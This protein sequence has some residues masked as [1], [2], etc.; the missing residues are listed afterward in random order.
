ML[1]AEQLLG[2]LR[3]RGEKD[4]WRTHAGAT[5]VPAHVEAVLLRQHHVEQDQLPLGSRPR[6][7]AV[8]AV[9]DDLDGMALDRE[10]IGQSKRDVGFVF[11]DENLAIV[12]C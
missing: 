6:A 3:P 8:D 4:D 10:I 12:S 11:D 9:G 5:E 2:L 7:T 1:E